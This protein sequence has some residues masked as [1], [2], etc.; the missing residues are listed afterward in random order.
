M[1]KK[2]G[3]G[4][5]G[6]EKQIGE[7]KNKYEDGRLKTQPSDKLDLIIYGLQE[8]HCKHRC[9]N[10]MKEIKMKKVTTEIMSIRKLGQ[11]H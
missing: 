1:Q 3:K 7:L 10:K 6:R 9:T 4:K 11:L 2:V 8:S 5:Q